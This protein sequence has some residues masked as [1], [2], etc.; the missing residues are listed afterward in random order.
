MKRYA[1]SQWRGNLRQG[2]GSI[3]TESG[4]LSNLAYSFARRFGEERG[5]NPEELVAAAHSSCYAMAVSAELE[6]RKLQAEL[7]DVKA[8]VTLENASGGWSIPSVHL[9]VSIE[10]SGA[11][12]KQIEEAA[13]SAKANCPISKLLKADI[14][15]N[16]NIPSQQSASFEL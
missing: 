12:R 8:T 16:L 7:I 9:D 6:Q 4:A 13:K 15:M 3:N 11:D 2:K 10:A 1:S 14:T 5:S